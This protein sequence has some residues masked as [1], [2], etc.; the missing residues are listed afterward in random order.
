M[1]VTRTYD[2]AVTVGAGMRLG[3][4]GTTT[5]ILFFLAIVFGLFSYLRTTAFRQRA[6]QNPWGI[7]PIAWGVLGFFFGVIGLLVA[8]LACV[9]TRPRP[10]GRGTGP[11]DRFADAPH[12]VGQRSATEHFGAPAGPGALASLPAPNPGAEATA[13]PPPG[14]HPD[15]SDPR[16][17]R[18]WMGDD[19]SDE[20][21]E[22]GV[23]SRSPLPPFP[24]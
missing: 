2:G 11:H 15:P 17:L 6:G 21:L 12:E 8:L 13:G 20:V 16:R 19:W 1:A 3:A 10:L 7:H 23:V 5:I 4:S 22:A 9:T 18:L 14:W 24:G